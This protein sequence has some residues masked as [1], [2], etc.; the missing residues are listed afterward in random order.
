MTTSVPLVVVSINHTE[1]EDCQATAVTTRDA[2]EGDIPSISLLI[3]ANA[4]Y[5]GKGSPIFQSQEQLMEDCFKSSPPKFYCM[6]CVCNNDVL[7]Y[8]LYHQSYS[9]WVGRAMSVQDFYVKEDCRGGIQDM[10]AR[11]L[12][13][14]AQEMGC[15]RIA[16]L[17]P[18][19]ATEYNEFWAKH[20]AIDLTVAEDWH[21]YRLNADKF[22]AFMDRC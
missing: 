9:T 21:Q 20:G 2:A 17:A 10:F 18:N 12:V 1:M 19:N 7:G 13:R 22:Q 11:N 3:A 8:T 4:E 5:L 6:V 16:W 15:R 14:R